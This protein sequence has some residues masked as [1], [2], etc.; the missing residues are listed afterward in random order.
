MVLDCR[1]SARKPDCLKIVFSGWQFPLASSSF[2]KG[3]RLAVIALLIEHPGTWR[4]L[5]L[6]DMFEPIRSPF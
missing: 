1:P 3:D 2:T 4:L 5:Q 6:V